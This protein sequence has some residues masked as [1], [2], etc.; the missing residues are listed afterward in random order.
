MSDSIYERGGELPLE[1]QHFK[2][3][4]DESVKIAGYEDK[5][6]GPL[7]V[8]HEIVDS[9]WTRFKDYLISLFPILRWILHYNLKWF[10]SDLIAGVTVGCV[11]VPQSMSYAQL[12]GLTPE[13]GLYSSFVGVLIYC[14]FATSKDVSIGPVAVMSLQVGKVVA[15]VQ[16]KHG[17]LYPA[18]VIATAVAFICGVVALGIGVLRLGF[19]LE[20]ISMPAVVGFMTGSA[21]NIV[22]GQVPALMGFNKLVNTR[23]ST[24][25]VIIETLKHL[26][27]STIDA[28]F[29][30]IPLFILYFWKYVCDFGP[31]RYPSKQKWFFYTSVMRNGV[32]IIFA[33]LVSW[34]A[35]YDWTHNKYPGGAK[36]VPWSILGTVPSG[37][38]HTGVM[39]MPNGIFSAFASQIPVSVII[40]LLEHISISKSFGR[41][42]DYKIVPDQE[43]IAIGVTN[44]LGTFFSAYPATGS[45]SR[46][47]LKAKCGVRTPLAGVYTG[48]VVLLALY[49][50]TEAFYFIPKASLSAV[51]IHAVGDLMAHWRVTWD[52]YL[53]A[54]L[55]AAIFLICVLVSVFSTIENGIYFAMAASAVTLLWRNLRTHGQ[56]LGRIKV[57]EVIDPIV[58]SRSGRSEYSESSSSINED[59][60][61]IEKKK[62]HIKFFSKDGQ[63][64]DIELQTKEY[65]KEYPSDQEFDPSNFDLSKLPKR[66]RFATRWVPIPKSKFP[67]SSSHTYANYINEEIEILPPPTGVIVYRPGEAFTY[68]NCSRHLDT[69]LDYMKSNTRRGETVVYKVKSDRP[70]NDPGELTWNFNSVKNIFKRKKNIDSNE[71]EIEV[72]ED[73][74]PIL[75]L[76]H[77]DFASVTGVDVTSIQALVDLRKAVSRYTGRDIEFHFSGIINPWIKKSL[78]NAGFGKPYQPLKGS[79]IDNAVSSEHRYY[80][81]GTSYDEHDSTFSAETYDDAELQIGR[82]R[83]YAVNST[84]TPFIHLDIPSY[85]YLE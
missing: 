16:E 38:K 47:A 7:D 12:A 43:V 32:V 69:L 42:N 10:Y 41:V 58:V 52:F 21:L 74:R 2:F 81:I 68:L 85:D 6:V 23:D 55:D 80:D 26:P 24:Y 44:L 18:H 51:I 57:A 20:F 83:Y 84:E 40:L 28:A 15:H 1:P 30:I 67:L 82:H 27:D 65:S 59:T 63:N 66:T 17:D 72:V 61:S 53:I 46:S 75:K 31:K 50:L 60:G 25:K 35:Y 70:W 78:I 29:G 76:I 3:A 56:F 49:A 45:F 48:V 62:I 9:P 33:T 8:L 19:L 4:N 39:E 14:F 71:D 22:A 13:F 79:T 73:K 54:P 5:Q 64:S 77:F 11:M 34:G 36:K 37:L